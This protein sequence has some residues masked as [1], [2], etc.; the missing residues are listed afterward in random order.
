MIFR[1][2]EVLD[3][4]L[5]CQVVKR[6]SGGWMA[7]IYEAQVINTNHTVIL[8]GI[9]KA[10]VRTKQDALEREAMVMKT[11]RMDTIPAFF[12]YVE[13][14]NRTYIIMEKRSGI[15]LEELIKRQML[16]E[17]VIKRIAL[18]ISR[19]LLYLHKKGLVYGD[20]KPSNML[21]DLRTHRTTLLDYG[22]V[23]QR[24][25]SSLHA[26]F[27][28][29]LGY[30]APECWKVSLGGVTEL[31]DIFALG[32]TLYRMLEQKNPREEF[33]RFFITDA[34]KKNRWQPILNK[35][36]ALQPEYRYQSTAQVYQA[37]SEIKI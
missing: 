2:G 24:G 31:A 19:T 35:C 32:V 15:N 28:G 13:E 23:S 5:P 37:I 7:E 8:K 27:Q 20:L 25:G 17:T 22:T 10:A 9:G 12:G 18:D 14:Q 16:E 30:A 34:Q 21:F 4:T 29:T 26:F 3:G 11:I 6:I 36:C 1:I 33:G